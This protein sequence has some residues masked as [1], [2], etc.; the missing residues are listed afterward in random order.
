[1]V[2]LSTSYFLKAVF[3]N[4]IWSILKYFVP[5]IKKSYL[6][7]ESKKS[8]TEGDRNFNGKLKWSCNINPTEKYVL[9]FRMKNTKTA[10]GGVYI[11]KGFL[12]I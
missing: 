5:Y 2:C 4:F 1:M 11:K 3:T 8:H 10:S 6:T 9:T 12:K 7:N